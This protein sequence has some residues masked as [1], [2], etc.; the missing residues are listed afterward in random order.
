MKFSPFVAVDSGEESWSKGEDI[1]VLASDM[2]DFTQEFA[3]RWSVFGLD[4]EVLEWCDIVISWQ[5]G[6]V[7]DFEAKSVDGWL[8][9]EDWFG[10]VDIEIVKF[11]NIS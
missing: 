5:D 9:C 7:G 3:K 11:E 10:D 6:V 1:G 2:C 8:R 4:D